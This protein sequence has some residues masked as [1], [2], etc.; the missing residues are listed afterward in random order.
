M[1]EDKNKQIPPSQS[2]VAGLILIQ[3][4]FGMNYLFSKIILAQLPPLVWASMRTLITAGILVSI[5]AFMGR[6]DFQRAFYY[7]RQLILFSLLGVALNQG[8]FLLGLHYTTVT[9]SALLNTLIPVFT[10][11]I[12]ALRGQEAVSLATG[13]GF[14]F[15]FVG[16]LLIHNPA[17]FSFSDK[18]VLGDLLIL[19][20]AISYSLFLVYS[21]RFFKKLD[22]VW[23][24]T[25]LFVYG[26]IALTLFAAPEWVGFRWRPLPATTWACMAV[27]ILGGTVAPYLLISFTLGRTQSSLVALFVYVQPLVAAVMSYL[28]FGELITTRTVF[29]GILIFLGVVLAITKRS[30]AAA[31]P[32][33]INAG[34]HSNILHFRKGPDASK[35]RV[36]KR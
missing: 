27:S 14:F 11:L 2:I 1:I 32:Q 5:S 16:V 34:P 19:V 13:V 36:E 28:F 8:L 6:L 25:W 12:V 21:H 30:I 17:S 22:F 24:T 10:L 29:A 9:N 7:Y 20:N 15:A 33:L 4:L 35:R 26:S 18:T 31:K 23:S 3:F